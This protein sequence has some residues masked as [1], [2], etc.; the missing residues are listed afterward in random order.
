[1][2]APRLFVVSGPA[3]AGKGTLVARARSRRPRLSVTVS[4]TTRSPREGEIDGTSYYFLTED[5]FDRKIEEDAFLEWAHVHKNRYGTL[6]SE[7]ERLFAQGNSVILEIDVQGAFAV[8]KQRPDAVLIFIVPP[9]MEVL[10]QRLRGRGTEDEDSIR[11]RLANAV[12]ELSLAGE[13]DE[14]VV[15][16]NVEQATEDLLKIIDS[17]EDEGGGTHDVRNEARD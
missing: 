2:S 17:Y 15:N 16:D 5:E 1:M 9:S 14:I 10:E 6:K 7:V 13:Y 12:H 4:A 3:G 8:R 11:V